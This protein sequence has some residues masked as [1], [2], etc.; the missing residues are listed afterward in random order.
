MFEQRGEVSCVAATLVS[1]AVQTPGRSRVV[2]SLLCIPRRWPNGAPLQH[3]MRGTSRSTQS[4]YLSG[5]AEEAQG[6]P[7]AADC[8]ICSSLCSHVM[9]LALRRSS[10]AS[11]RTRACR[12]V[13]CIAAILVPTNCTGRRTVRRVRLAVI[14]SLERSPIHFA[15][16]SGGPRILPAV[17]CT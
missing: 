14:N 13:C 6:C 4:V 11:F 16:C 2:P 10:N 7:P 17:L 8:W 12:D 1:P 15:Y 9:R 3:Y 5:I